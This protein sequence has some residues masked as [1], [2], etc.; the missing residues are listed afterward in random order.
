MKCFKFGIRT[1]ADP[2]LYYG[3]KLGNKLY[4]ALRMYN[5]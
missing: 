1:K 2:L 5:V 4:A 3:L